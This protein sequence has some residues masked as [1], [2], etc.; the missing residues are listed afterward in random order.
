MKKRGLTLY[1]SP[2]PNPSG[3][4]KCNSYCGL[5][6][7][8]NKQGLRGKIGLFIPGLFSYLSNLQKCCYL[9]IT[10]IQDSPINKQEQ[11]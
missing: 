9:H 1:F 7:R 3:V 10:F 5:I 6:N 2:N 11:V 8:D 4:R